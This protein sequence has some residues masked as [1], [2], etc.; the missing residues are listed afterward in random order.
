M[1]KQMNSNQIHIIAEYHKNIMT[2]RNKINDI[3]NKFFSDQNGVLG[4][5]NRERLSKRCESNRTLQ[6][7]V[8]LEG[9][10]QT[11][12]V[13]AELEQ[14]SIKFLRDVQQHYQ[15]KLDNLSIHDVYKELREASTLLKE[16]V[17]VGDDNE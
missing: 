8:Y 14:L 15:S 6:I 11:I 7:G 3:N 1:A 17:K 13:D 16:L 4:I 9:T 10:G 12:D 5:K 2:T